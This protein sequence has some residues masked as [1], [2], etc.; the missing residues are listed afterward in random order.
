MESRDNDRLAILTL[1]AQWF[2]A[3][4]AGEPERL[5]A[6]VTDDFLFK[7]PGA[8]EIVGKT[9][10]HNILA[11]FLREHTETV[12]HQVERN[13]G[14]GDFA[15]ALVRE[16]GQDLSQGRRRLLHPVGLHLAVLHRGEDGSWKVARDVA[17]FDAP[18]PFP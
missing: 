1:Y 8:P 5:T 15:W 14:S 2:G 9:V 12:Q 17:A 13:G 16:Q 3:L 11:A 10:F 6:R 18:P 7:V 4:E